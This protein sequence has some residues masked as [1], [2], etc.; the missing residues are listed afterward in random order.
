MGKHIKRILVMFL[1]VSIPSCCYQ[2]SIVTSA[3]MKENKDN[4]II[5]AGTKKGSIIK[6]EFPVTL[7]S[8]DSGIY[9]VDSTGVKFIKYDDLSF[10]TVKKTDYSKTLWLSV[11]LSAAGILIFYL[12][13]F[14][15]LRIG[16]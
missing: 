7:L 8:A 13:Q 12:Y 10:V 5:Q 15:H 9:V 16:G 11:G 4:L 2:S 3:E 1:L 14:T 6:N